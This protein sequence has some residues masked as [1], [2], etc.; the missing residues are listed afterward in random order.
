MPGL[1]ILAVAN[2]I[3]D[4]MSNP[5]MYGIAQAYSTEETATLIASR[6]GLSISTGFIF[7]FST[8]EFLPEQFGIVTTMGLSII[9][10]QPITMIAARI[11]TNTPISKLVHH[12]NLGVTDLTAGIQ[13]LFF[14]KPFR[15]TAIC[16]IMYYSVF[17]HVTSLLPEFSKFVL[18]L[19]ASQC[20]FLLASWSIR[21]CLYALS[22]S[23]F[24]GKKPINYKAKFFVL[25]ILGIVFVCFSI[26]REFRY[27]VSLIA[28]VD[29]THAVTRSVL[30]G[31]LLQLCD[32]GIIGRVRGNINSLI[33]AVI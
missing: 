26:S 25:G 7:E 28:L 21:V 8:E 24:W 32:S 18:H 14:K 30:D 10:S 29:I 5:S 6:T 4:S 2:T 1:I 19:D 23:I 12:K 11:R 3:A 15:D 17:N 20:G 33:S 27:A 16:F 22:L 9:T 13:Q 31:L